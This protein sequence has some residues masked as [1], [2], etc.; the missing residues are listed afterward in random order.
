MGESYSAK[1][2]QVLVTS[3][4]PKRR[5]V[6]QQHGLVTADTFFF[7]FGIKNRN[8]SIL[9]SKIDF[10]RKKKAQLGWLGAIML[11]LKNKGE[12]V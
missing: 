6:Q 9:G 10:R 2:N 8:I 5:D 12:T 7:D 1:N 11:K 4:R 3:M